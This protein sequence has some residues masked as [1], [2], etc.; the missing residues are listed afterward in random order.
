MHGGVGTGEPSRQ[1]RER[2]SEIARRA[3]PIDR[4]GLDRKTFAA[5][6]ADRPRHM[7]GRGNQQP[8]LARFGLHQLF[9]QTRVFCGV[10]RAAFQGDALA[11]DAE[12]FEQWQHEIGLG[13]TAKQTAAAPEKTI[14]AA[15]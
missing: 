3:A 2:R 13:G 15:G 7:I 8:A 10:A 6:D 14:C 12:T 5:E 4:I 9:G 1:G 11:R